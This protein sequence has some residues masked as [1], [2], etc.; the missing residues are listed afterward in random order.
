MLA[1]GTRVGRKRPHRPGG[2]AR[3]THGGWTDGRAHRQFQAGVRRAPPAGAGRRGDH[4]QRAAGDPR[5]RGAPRCGGD[6]GLERG[7]AGGRSPVAPGRGAGDVRAPG[8]D[9]RSGGG[10]AHDGRARAGR[11]MRGGGR[12]LGR[13]PGLLDRARVLHR[14][15]HPVVRH[16]SARDARGRRPTT[17]RW[18]RPGSPWTRRWPRSPTARSTTRSRWSG[19]TGWRAAWPSKGAG[20]PWARGQPARSSRWRRGFSV[21]PG[22]GRAWQSACRRSPSGRR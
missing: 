9:P 10:S 17:R 7:A 2:M 22:C 4:G 16:R 11:G 21:R 8:R 3:S 19:S 1:V 12:N 5:D 6:P 15:A 18:R 14:A 20:G 13:R